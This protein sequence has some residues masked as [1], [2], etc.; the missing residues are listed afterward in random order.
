MMIWFIIKYDSVIVHCQLVLSKFFKYLSKFEI[1][2]YV[3]LVER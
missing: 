3:S 2:G 1:V